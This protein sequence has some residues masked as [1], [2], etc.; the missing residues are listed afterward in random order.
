[1]LYFGLTVG[2]PGQAS[3]G[4]NVMGLALARV[5]KQRVT[6]TPGATMRQ[7]LANL[8]AIEAAPQRCWAR[9]WASDGRTLPTGHR[10]CSLEALGGA[11]GGTLTLHRSQNAPAAGP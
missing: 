5:T 9:L 2:G 7:G 8:R 10:T 6:P 3:A 1:M 4:M 11:I